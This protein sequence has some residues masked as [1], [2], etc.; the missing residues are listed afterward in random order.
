MLP[1]IVVAQNTTSTLSGSVKT[2]TGE[3]LNGATIIATHEPTGTVYKVQA[4]TGGRYNISNMN[5][6]GP[7]SV[8]VSFVN[9]QNEKKGDIYLGLGETYKIDFVLSSKADDLGEV[10]VKTTTKKTTDFT[11]KGGAETFIT[12]EKM[13]NLPTVGRNLQDY[14][15]FVPQAKVASADGNLAGVSFGGQNN[16]YNSFYVDGAA[17]NDQFGLSGSGTNGGQTGSSPISIDAIDQI[18]VILSPYDASIGNFTGAGINATTK[19]GTNKLQASVYTFFRNQDLTGKTPNGDK[20]LATKL[21]KFSSKTYGFRVGGPIVKNK[22]FFFLNVDLVRDERPQPWTGT[23][24]GNTALN[25]PNFTSLMTKL[26][27]YGYDPGGYLN[28]VEE[29]N[30]NRVAAKIDWNL[31]TAHKLTLSYRYSKSDRFNVPTSSNTSINFYNGGYLMPNVTHSGSAELRS[32]FKKGATNKLLLTFTDVTDDRGPLGNPFPRVTI[33]DGPGRFTF[34]T[35]N[36]ST[37]NLLT[38]KN[39]ALLDYFKITKGKHSI[40][41]GTDNEYT[42]AMNVFIRDNFGNY[43]FATMN[44]FLNNAYPSVYSRSFSLLDNGKGDNTS[45]AAKFSF[46]RLAGFINDEVALSDNFTLN[47]G[48]RLDY[49]KFL[50]SPTKDDFFNDIALPK[51]SNYYDLQGARSGKISNPKASLSPRI[52]FTYKIPEENVVFRGGAG[53]FAG[54]IPLVWPGGVYNNTGK[55]VGGVGLNSI[56]AT[57]AANLHFIP[58]PYNQPTAQSLGINISN[59]KGQV[60]LI[61]KD[62]RLPKVFRASLAFDKRFENGWSLTAEVIVTKNINEIYYQN[63]NILPPALKAT[64]P[65]NRNVYSST[66]SAPFIPINPNNT[67]PYT[68]IYLISNNKGDKGFA[69]NFTL[70][71]NKNFSNGLSF[72]ASYAYGH[73][74]VTYEGTS[75]Q[76]NSQYNTLATVNGRNFAGRHRSNF[77][78]GHRITAYLSKKFTYAHKAMSTTVS[79]FYTGQSGNPLT[80]VYNGSMV[81]DVNTGNSQDLIYIPTAADINNAVFITDAGLTPAQQKAAL[82]SFIQGNKYLNTRRG[83]YAENN[84]DRLPFTHVLDFNIKQDFNVKIG[85]NRYQI[86]VSYDIFNF[87][88]M[89]NRDWGRQYFVNFNTYSLMRFRG[90]QANSTIPT[91]SFTPPASGSVHTV[92]TSTAPSFSARWVS[93][94]GVR[95][96]LF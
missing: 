34:G 35:E 48:V 50:Y 81:R 86:Q 69:H 82:E 36:F 45:A 7:Y 11:S 49:T 30:S 88:N 10:T 44:D 60:D 78:L 1:T 71:T 27:G 80:Y 61:A 31:N 18:Q 40:T 64:G 42:K 25:S 19:S 8:V 20:S 32:I 76:N 29:V 3:P 23:Y 63:V 39:F 91:Y 26:A 83:E 33:L 59:A 54:R 2:N 41:I 74:E 24:A 9:F 68:G 90:Y 57:T 4:R 94:L 38:Q 77:D 21:A 14:L 70:S 56:A 46:A 75:S 67:N 65:D 62:F 17:N 87:S 72:N 95:L 66:G 79:L 43:T 93:Q 55:S 37:A 5:P 85:K 96:S 53:L 51:I 92:S 52:G 47:F 16:R 13:E 22:A 58:D 73:S 12:K 28:N 84:G 6:G 15:R 89:L